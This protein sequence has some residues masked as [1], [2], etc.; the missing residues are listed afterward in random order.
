V[1]ESVEIHEPLGL[2]ASAEVLHL[3][4][5]VRTLR[6]QAAPLVARLQ[7][8]RV[9]MVNSTAQGGGV[10]EMLPKLV[11]ILNELGLETQWV[12]IGTD[13]PLF[14][15]FTKRLHNLIHGT[16]DPGLTNEDSQLYAAVSSENAVDLK[17]RMREGD[18]VVIHDPQPLGVGALLKQELGIPFFFRCHIGFDEETLE[19]RA[20]WN[21]LQPYAE[22]C[23]YALFSASEY[24]PDFLAA[25]AGLIRP[26]LDPLSYKNR[27]LGVH[28]V[29]GILR[30]AGLVFSRHPVV[31]P[32]FEELVTRLRPDGSFAPLDEASDIGLLFRPIV[33]Q[34]SRWD[35]LK[36]F[37]PL[38]EGFVRLKSALRAPARDIAVRHRRRLE[39]ARLV[40]A[41]PDPAAVADDPEAEEAL[42]DLIHIYRRLEPALQDDVALLS[43]PMGSRKHNA[44]IV[45]AL[46]RCSS[47]VVQNSLREGFG[48]TITEAMWKR[49]AVLGSR[50]CGIR[51]QIRDGIDGRFIAD[52]EDAQQI[53]ELLDL[54]LDD[55]PGRARYGRSAQLRVR[56][57]FLV[58]TQARR[59]LEV[60]AEHAGG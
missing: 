21:F 45:N 20:A 35:R 32:P 58:F 18:I 9:W 1:I 27:E 10:A 40:L 2:D 57:E 11:S 38:L 6:Q 3:A 49:C 28:K 39:Q 14:F 43:L 5:A 17:G 46:Q 52:C 8:R 41:G 25:K 13:Q 16:G 23:D 44:L 37:E 56:D 42:Q 31:P 33:S 55:V 60:L 34:I 51:Q 53:A 15:E 54:V 36:G 12:A 19:T 24:I 50:A 29:A 30:N 47:V 59:W 7:G 4:D 48:L 22:R 26:A